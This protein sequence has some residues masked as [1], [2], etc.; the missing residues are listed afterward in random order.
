MS[1][2]FLAAA[3]ALRAVEISATG[4]FRVEGPDGAVVF[5]LEGPRRVAFAPACSVDGGLASKAMGGPAATGGARGGAS[6][7]QT[8][9]T[10]IAATPLTTLTA[11][12]DKLYGFNISIDVPANGVL[13]AA[14]ESAASAILGSIPPATIATHCGTSYP[15]R[16]TPLV[17]P[18][19]FSS[20]G[21]IARLETNVADVI[22]DATFELAK[23]KN[24]GSFYRSTGL[25][26][27]TVGAGD[28]PP[29]LGVYVEDGSASG[30][31]ATRGP[32]FSNVISRDGV[33]AYAS[34]ADIKRD[35]QITPYVAITGQL[36]KAKGFSLRFEVIRIYVSSGS[37]ASSNMNVSLYTAVY[38]APPGASSKTVTLLDDLDDAELAGVPSPL[39]D[40]FRSGSPVHKKAKS[41]P[42]PP[43]APSKPKP[44]RGGARSV[45]S[46]ESDDAL[47]GDDD[48]GATAP[49]VVVDPPVLTRLG[50]GAGAAAIAP[51]RRPVRGALPLATVAL[52]ASR[53]E[54]ADGYKTPPTLGEKRA[55]KGG[56]GLGHAGVGK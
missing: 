18:A 2:S 15:A 49:I 7:F 35:T 29:L 44:V 3:S 25:A 13:E 36:N 55:S 4:A 10:A 19:K 20:F 5:N 12:A 17:P 50:H 26:F 41:A 52:S 24:G 30:G 31:G 9:S 40:E 39:L 42:A 22:L 21:G 8:A 43:P 14:F 16:H 27:K 54:D 56:K 38:P 48:D 45:I 53:G 33:K 47:S 37:A 1:T 32:T 23:T 6:A 51:V 28:A 46:Q 11:P 34:I